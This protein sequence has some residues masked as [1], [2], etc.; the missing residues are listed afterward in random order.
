MSWILALLTACTGGAPPA[1]GV[2]DDEARVYPLRTITPTVK[3]ADKNRDSEPPDVL[4]LKDGWSRDGSVDG[5]ERWSRPLP[6]RPRSLFFFRAKPGM[7]VLVDGEPYAYHNGRNAGPG[8]WRNDKDTLFVTLPAGVDPA[9]ADVAFRYPKATEREAKLHRAYNPEGTDLDFASQQ[10][11][12]GW[13]A[14]SGLLLPAPSTMEWTLTLPKAAELHFVGG[15]ARPELLDQ[16]ASDGAKLIVEVVVDGETHIVFDHTVTPGRFDYHRADLSTWED[17]EAVVRFRSDPSGTVYGDHVFV[18][19]PV[20]ASRKANPRTVLMVFI[21][22]LRPDHLSLY[23]YDRDTSAAI[24]HLAESAAVF[25]NARSIAP[26]TLPSA[27]TIVTGRHPE[28]YDDTTTLQETLRGEGWATAFIAGNVYLSANFDMHRGWDLHRV[29]MWP[30]AEQVTDDALAWLDA[31]QGRDALLMVHYMDAH[32]PYLEPR[33]YRHLYAGAGP[34]GLKGEFHLPDVRQARLKSDEDR[35]YVRDRYDNNIR[36]ATDQIQRLVSTL[37]DNDVLMLFA[38]HGEEFWDHGGFEHG[39]STF[40]ELLRVPLVIRAPGVPAGTI[41]TRVSL[42]DLTPTILDLVDIDPEEPPDGRSLVPLAQGDPE[43]T[44]AFEERPHGFGRPLYGTERWGVI[45][46]DKKWSV[47]QGREVLYDLAADAGES[48]NLF[49]KNHKDRGKPYRAALSEA[50]DLP[51]DVS[52]RFHPTRNH[53]PLPAQPLEVICSVPGGVSNAWIGDDP[54]DNA[55]ALVVKLDDADA[56]WARLASWGAEH[57]PIDT[58][59][60]VELVHMQFNR[61]GVRE[62]YVT[63]TQGVGAEARCS[64]RYCPGGE[65]SVQTLSVPDNRRRL[66]NNRSVIARAKW[67]G[68]RKLE[69][70]FGIA[71]FDPRSI[72]ARDD[73]LNAALEEMGY[74]DR[75]DEDE[76]EEAV[77]DDGGSKGA[78]GKTK[79]P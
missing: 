69:W 40:D 14:R 35:Q 72:R 2:S 62:V 22:T 59:D 5:G 53:G 20:V 32:L 29:G 50:L 7:D 24:D 58:E 26:W 13:D 46:G 30:P 55:D 12:E 54:L 44:R 3:L 74:K 76:D 70:S 31:R 42:L 79:S 51:V 66:D 18:G 68:G 38:D 19:E 56:G 8:T 21:D 37:D 16:P 39:H 61:A 48:N 67:E 6:V 63:P 15:L 57:A 64:A 41:D 47:H 28:A 49:K 1:D 43:A 73:E 9:T 75:G 25:T 52:W 11:Q 10:V 71:P 33:A 78:K 60:D 45:D 4:H 23:G 77:P 17:K 65:C 34:N 36:Y 27:R